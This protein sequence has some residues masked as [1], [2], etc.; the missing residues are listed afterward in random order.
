MPVDLY[1]VLDVPRN[2]KP[3]AVKRGYRRKAMATHPDRGG[4]AAAFRMVQLAYRT[5]SDDA[6]RA[7]YDATGEIPSDAPD[8]TTAKVMRTVALA[9]DAVF[10]WAMGSGQN[11]TEVEFLSFMRSHIETRNAEI[12]SELAKLAKIRASL[13]AVMERFECKDGVNDLA[14]M[15]EEQISGADRKIKPLTAEKEDGERA[16]E[17]LKRFSFKADKKKPAAKNGL[18]T[19]FTARMFS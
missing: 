11:P 2:A 10:S 17:F 9:F 1:K 18:T 16:L 14:V 12:A 8:N 19:M 5:L 7:A 3:D 6:K 4:D 13:V 15:V